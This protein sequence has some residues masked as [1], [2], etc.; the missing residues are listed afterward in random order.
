MYDFPWIAA[1]NDALWASIGARLGEAGICAP[2]ALTRGGDLATLWRHP[3]LIFGQ[4]CGYPYVTALKEMVALIATP[5]YSSPGCEG[6]SHRSFIIRRV[7]GPRRAL[8][9][10]R[11]AIAAINAHYSNTA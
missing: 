6:A 8:A 7:D 4:T 2:L 11:G 10:F 9:E 3:A 1:A 5:E